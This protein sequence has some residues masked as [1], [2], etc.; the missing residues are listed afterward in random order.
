M[1]SVMANRELFNDVQLKSA[2]KKKPL[3][4]IRYKEAKIKEELRKNYEI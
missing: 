4:K 3:C 2:S 1:Q